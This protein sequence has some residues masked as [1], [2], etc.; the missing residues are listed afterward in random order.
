[1]GFRAKAQVRDGHGA[2][3]LRVVYE[4]ALGVVVGFFTD[5]LDRVL[6][7]ANGTVGA[8]AV[9]HAAYGFFR[10]DAEGGS[11]SMLVKVRSSLIPTVKWFFGL[12]LAISSKRPLTIAG[13]NS[14]EKDRSGRR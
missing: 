10:F 6:V 14:L 9:E 5:D 2:G 12:S 11:K 7:G 3:F 8:E 13:V 4:E 1:M